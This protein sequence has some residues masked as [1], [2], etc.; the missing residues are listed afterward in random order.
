MVPTSTG[1][2]RERP[3]FTGDE[4]ERR[5]VITVVNIHYAERLAKARKTGYW[6]DLHKL[7]SGI[8]LAIGRPITDHEHPIPFD[9]QGDGSFPITYQ[10][11][12]GEVTDIEY[13]PW[14]F[15]RE[16]NKPPYYSVLYANSMPFRAFHPHYWDRVKHEAYNNYLQRVR[17]GWKVVNPRWDFEMAEWDLRERR[18]MIIPVVR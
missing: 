17:E 15:P 8:E 18:G 11:A 14:I 16:P 5:E 9:Y 7:Q 2:E 1:V 4:L 13:I 10:T 6:G 3:P 12:E